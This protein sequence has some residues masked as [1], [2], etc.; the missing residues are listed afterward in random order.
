MA[1]NIASPIR[2]YGRLERVGNTWHLLDLPPHVSLRVKGFFARINKGQTK[3]FVL[4][5]SPGTCSDLLWFMQR[6]PMEMATAD[7]AQL[8]LGHDDTVITQRD[9]ERILAPDFAGSG[10]WGFLP[11]RQPYL[12]QQQAAEMCTRLGRLLL[13]DDVGL[14]KTVSALASVD[15]A[16]VAPVAVVA[17]T[18]LTEQWIEDYI[19]PFTGRTAHVIKGTK[20]YKLPPADFYLFAYSNYHGWVDYAA[21]GD[22]PAVIFDEIQTLRTGQGTLKG[23]TAAAFARNARLVMGLTATPIYNYGPEIFNILE[24][25][26]PGC[27]GTYLEF[28]TE[29]CKAGP[30]GHTVV[31]DPKALG[32]FL[33][34]QGVVLRRTEPDVGSQMPPLNVLTHNVPYDQDIADAVADEARTLALRVIS[35]SFMDRGAAARELDMLARH[36]TGMAKAKGV[37]S[38]VRMLVESGRKVLLGGWHRDV[39]DVWLREMA[40]LKPVMFTGSETKKQKRES[41]RRFISSETDLMIMSL[42]SGTGLDGLQDVAHTAVA[43]ELDWSPQVMRQFFGRLRRPGQKEQVDAIYALTNGGSDPVLVEMLGLKASQAHGIVDPF[44]SSAGVTHSDD[45]RI[46]KLAE[47][48][49]QRKA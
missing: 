29:W 14:G 2:T 1:V 49:L 32:A 37:A 35:G 7:R 9:V 17:E 5:D 25:V 15:R 46:K 12:Y 6:F 33:R 45:S 10:K 40:D 16:K 28:D 34:E 30:S 42:R 31:A 43:G 13:L 22:F 21:R 39:Y 26:A 47:A 27:L 41:K 48:Y 23:K 38:L 19:D 24:I 11:G 44:E 4:A 3:N 8:V 18:H 20:P 36:A